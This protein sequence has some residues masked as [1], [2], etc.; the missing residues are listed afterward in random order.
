MTRT[1]RSEGLVQTNMFHVDKELVEH[2]NRALEKT[3]GRKTGLSSFSIDKRGE[4]PEVEE[5]LGK[6]YLQC[7]PSHRYLITVSPDQ[8]NVDLIHEEFSFDNDIVNSLYD[9]FLPQISIATRIDGLYGQIDDGV[10]TYQSIDDLLLLRKVNLELH[11]PSRFLTKAVELQDYIKSLRDDPNLLIKNDS[12][13]P[14]KILELIHEVGDITSYNLSAIGQNREV[15]TFYTRLFGGVYVFRDGPIKPTISVRRPGGAIRMRAESDGKRK[16]VVIH[17][18]QETNP[19]GGPRV[20][21]IPIDSKSDVID[22]L[23]EE[24]YTT[25]SQELLATRLYRIEDITLLGNG[26]DVAKLSQEER[27]LALSRCKMSQDWKELFMIT[28]RMAS[29]YSFESATENAKPDV[30]AILLETK[31]QKKPIHAVVE[32]LL[33]RL[34]SYDYEKMFEHNL[35]DLEHVFERSDKMTQDYILNVLKQDKR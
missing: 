15:S 30:K 6:N 1:L 13:V 28:K 9:N 24:G 26:Y 8:K 33:T 10:R 12:E 16:V 19:E 23:I 21:Y 29:G 20:D 25:L 34:W 2:Y 31:Q 11:T 7:S 17:E 4:S 5:E 22:F 14:K 35:R 27:A 32:N 18:E 3:T